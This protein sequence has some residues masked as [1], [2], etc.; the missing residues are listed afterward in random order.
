LPKIRLGVSHEW[1]TVEAQRRICNLLSNM[2]QSGAISNL[3]EHWRADRNDFQCSVNGFDVTGSLFVFP[4][5]VV[6]VGDFPASAMPFQRQIEEL[7]RTH[8]RQALA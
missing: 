4:E 2:R 5:M 8:A 7:I 6:F 3:K 1:D